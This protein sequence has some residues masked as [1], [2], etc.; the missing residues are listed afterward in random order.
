MFFFWDSEY[1]DYANLFAIILM[2]WISLKKN[3]GY[4]HSVTKKYY[5][6]VIKRYCFRIETRIILYFI[7]FE[8]SINGT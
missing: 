2:F 6:I 3:S 1:K 7:Y 8:R 5:I 4:V